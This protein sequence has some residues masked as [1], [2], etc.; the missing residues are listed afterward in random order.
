MNSH[1]KQGLFQLV[2]ATFLHNSEA[3]ALSIGIVISLTLLFKKPARLYLYFFLSF[4][5][6]LA[7]FEYL[8]HL[9]DPL[10][11]QTVTTVITEEGHFR[12]KRLFDLF[13]NDLVP[14][15]LYLLG[16]GFLFFGISKAKN[17]E[18]LGKKKNEKK[19]KKTSEKSF[20]E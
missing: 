12:A 14:M 2:Y 20:Q 19:A 9:V 3:I 15:I 10:Q 1:V 6:L 17:D 8:K 13:F 5:L 7:R 16:W 11:E 18:L 4:S